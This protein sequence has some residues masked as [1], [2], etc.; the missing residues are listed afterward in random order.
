MSIGVFSFILMLVFNLYSNPFQRPQVNSPEILADGKVAFRVEAPDAKSVKLS[1][2][3]IPNIWQGLDMT[4]NDSGTWEIQLDTLASGS[5]RYKFV[6][7][8]VLVV[9]P[10]NLSTSESNE[11]MWSLIHIPGSKFMDSC[12]VLHGAVS[13][14]NYSSKTLG[15]LR[16]MHVY[17]PPGYEAGKQ[18][19][20]VLYLLHGAFDSDDSWSTVGRAGIILDNLIASGEAV[21]M[22]IVMPK[23][24]TGPFN[25][26]QALPGTEPFIEDFEKDIMP[27]IESNYRVLDGRSSHAV[28]GLSMG[29]WHT[30]NIFA[31]N[32]DKFGYVGVFSSGIFD[33]MGAN[34]GN[35]GSQKPWQEQY[36]DVL[37]DQELKK[38][39]QLF[40]VAVG[41]EDFLIDTSDKTVKLLGDFGFNIVYKKTEGAHTWANWR[42][43]LNEFAPQ[44]FQSVSSQKADK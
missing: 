15:R 39:L 23:G 14:V 36:Q 21:P 16:R 28:A 19:Y 3:D 29:G 22:I 10:A 6:V 13:E 30:L 9:D 24:H 42:D 4:K 40:W 11:V 43:Y 20:P 18:Q 31:R 7:D 26:G 1:S 37:S 38:G 35:A 32:M 12:N 17:T 5:Y 33:L 8:S 25:M 44:L 41:K 2:S 34:A 27:Y